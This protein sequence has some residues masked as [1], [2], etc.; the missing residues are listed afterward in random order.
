MERGRRIR[1]VQREQAERDRKAVQR[2][3]VATPTK[4]VSPVVVEEEEDDHEAR[5]E[6]TKA[7]MLKYPRFAEVTKDARRMRR[8]MSQTLLLNT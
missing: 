1:E 2:R 3:R 4:P 6:R 7:E 8:K 5:W